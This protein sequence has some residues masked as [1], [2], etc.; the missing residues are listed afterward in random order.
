MME[1]AEA[2]LSEKLLLVFRYFTN[3]MVIFGLLR[4]KQLILVSKIILTDPYIISGDLQ[5]RN[6]TSLKFKLV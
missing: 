2:I 5:G 4:A 6:H 1:R 3:K